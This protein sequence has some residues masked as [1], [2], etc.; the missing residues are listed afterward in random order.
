[1]NL[2]WSTIFGIVSGFGLFLYAIY[3]ST[4][5]WIIFVSLASLAMV[6]GGTLGAT[7]IAYQG[8]YVF[9]TLNALFAILVP[10]A[11]SAVE[12]QKDVAAVVNW[13][14]E[15]KQKGVAVLDEKVENG[16]FKRLG[17]F[18]N[19]AY[20]LLASGYKGQELR[21]LLDEYVEHEYER[22]NV[23]VGILKNMAAF[24]PAFG[25]VGT[26]VGLVI[27]LDQLQ[28]DPS[29]IGQ[30]LALA[31]ITTLYGVIFANLLFKPAAN[32]TQ[33]KNQMMRF[34]HQLLTEGFVGISNKIEPIKLQ[35]LLN[36]RLNPAVHVD[37]FANKAA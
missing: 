35:D 5:H 37:V 2:S 10:A 26:L 22:A 32:K 4:D 30:G 33:Q 18:G 25:M 28:G 27:M 23:Q 15:V 14:M 20:Q 24:A 34:R 7:F 12:L 29:A 8:V 16:E 6:V 19:W 1:M 31:L 36:T 21:D 9:R 3:S 11:A 13:A 17:Q